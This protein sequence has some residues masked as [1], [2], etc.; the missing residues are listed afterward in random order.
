MFNPVSERNQSSNIVPSTGCNLKEKLILSLGMSHSYRILFLIH[1][2]SGMDD[3]NPNFPRN[4]DPKLIANKGKVPTGRRIDRHQNR[5]VT[6]PSGGVISVDFGC[7][8]NPDR[9]VVNSGATGSFEPDRR[10]VTEN[11]KKIA[12]KGGSTIRSPI[13]IGQ[14][15]SEVV[16]VLSF[17]SISN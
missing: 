6:Q 13:Q 10:I 17:V 16:F 5:Q 7:R 15:V 14:K 8:T 11:L 9:H 2:F 4:H 12:S 3:F 1:L